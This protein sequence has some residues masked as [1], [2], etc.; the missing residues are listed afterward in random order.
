MKSMEI[1]VLFL[2]SPIL[3]IIDI[4]IIIVKIILTNII[5]LIVFIIKKD[6]KSQG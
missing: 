5:I 1:Q 2:L 6:F 4:S 3:V